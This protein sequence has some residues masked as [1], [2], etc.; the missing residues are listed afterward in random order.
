MFVAATEAAIFVL[1]ALALGCWHWG[2][3][4]GVH[5]PSGHTAAAAVVYG[6]LIAL[7]LPHSRGSAIATALVILAC[8]AVIGTSRLLLQMHTLPDVL[9]GGGVGWISAVLLVRLAGRPPPNWPPTGWPRR[10]LAWA[11]LA[12]LVGV[13]VAAHGH[14][15][16]LEALIGRLANR[17]LSCRGAPTLAERQAQAF[18]PRLDER[19]SV[20]S[21]VSV[22]PIIRRL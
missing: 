20:I 2:A 4:V 6:G 12:S 5:S 15:L 19:D 8:A 17:A 16:Q 18:F 11:L 14:R 22:V 13:S 3:S 10:Y 1:K 7:L 21:E 9:V